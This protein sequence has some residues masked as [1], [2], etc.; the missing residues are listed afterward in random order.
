MDSSPSYFYGGSKI[1]D[2]IKKNIPSAKFLLMLRNPV[3]RFTSYYNFIKSK[4]II[5]D[6][7]ESF[8]NKSL[9]KF[10]LRD[11]LEVGARKFFARRYLF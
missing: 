2:Y 10:E 1:I 5:N 8:F 11:Q 6:D 9:K 3:D 4:N 7:F